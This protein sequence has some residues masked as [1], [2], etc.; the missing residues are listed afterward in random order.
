MNNQELLLA[1]KVAVSR[2]V[3]DHVIAA[4]VSWDS[5]LSKLVLSYYLDRDP[6]EDDEE[7]CEL[8]LGDLIAE[9]SEI[10]TAAKRCVILHSVESVTGLQGIVYRKD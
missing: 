8:A 4:T 6:M 1:S 3:N 10:V 7:Q 5:N 9:F 2:N